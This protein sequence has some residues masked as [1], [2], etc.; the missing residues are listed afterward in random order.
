MRYVNGFA[1]DVPVGLRMRDSRNNSKK[2]RFIHFN[3]IPS[4]QFVTKM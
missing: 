1:T 3:R 4:I 2:V